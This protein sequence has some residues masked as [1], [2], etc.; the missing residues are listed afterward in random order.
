[1]KH[2]REDTLKFVFLFYYK[3]PDY[4]IYPP[5]GFGS[6]YFVKDFDSVAFRH[7]CASVEYRFKHE[8]WVHPKFLPKDYKDDS[9]YRSFYED[10]AL[11][12]EYLRKNKDKIKSKWL[13][14][15]A[16]IRGVFKEK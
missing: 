14:R 15:E 8:R 9:L 3:F 6:F 2:N 7:F 12:R 11:F 5:S 13:L 1:M 10:E 16:E 4:V